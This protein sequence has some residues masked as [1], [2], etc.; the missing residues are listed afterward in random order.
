MDQCNKEYE[1][2]QSHTS[3]DL[4]PCFIRRPLSMTNSSTGWTILFGMYQMSPSMSI[5]CQTLMVQRSRVKCMRTRL[6]FS[7][8]HNKHSL[9][10]KWEL[11][12]CEHSF[13]FLCFAVWHQHFHSWY[14][15]SNQVLDIR[16]KQQRSIYHFDSLAVIKVYL[17]GLSVWVI[18]KL[19]N[20][21]WLS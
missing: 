18:L 10:W 8:V 19:I 7:D 14:H 13:F 20:W 15:R 9:Y 4:F 3:P 5:R 11:C 16:Y 2:Q 12:N 1:E 17:K 6:F 21:K